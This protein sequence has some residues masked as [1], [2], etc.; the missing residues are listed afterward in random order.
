[1]HDASAFVN[2][3]PALL[4][5]TTVVLRIR[6]HVCEVD[7]TTN[8]L[9]QQAAD[10]V[11][12]DRVNLYKVY[13]C[14]LCYAGPSH[15]GLMVDIC[16]LLANKVTADPDRS[17]GVVILPNT[18]VHGSATTSMGP[19]V[20][21]RSA[22]QMFED[23]AFKLEVRDFVLLC[24][25][26]TM[27]SKIRS[28]IHPALMLFSDSKHVDK[29]NHRCHFAESELYWRKAVFSIP[30]L[31]RDDFVNPASLPTIDGKQQRLSEA[32]EGKQ[33]ITGVGLWT[34]AGRARLKRQSPAPKIKPGPHSPSSVRPQVIEALWARM[35]VTKAHHAAF[36][37][38]LPYDGTLAQAIIEMQTLDGADVPTA[39]CSSVIWAGSLEDKSAIHKYLFQEVRNIIYKLSADGTY[40]VPGLAHMP[41]VSE[42]SEM[43]PTY[44]QEDYTVTR[45][46]DDDTLP[47]LQSVRPFPFK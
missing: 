28:L 24:D 15:G 14:N 46:M 33:H 39:S 4:V 6:C 36:I 43:R 21:Q 32:A 47:V 1:M 10:T 29:P 45:P 7:C 8:S 20:A 40:N 37:D 22:T 2:A 19:T 17:V 35:P 42:T 13:V 27:Y 12:L 34:K 23:A 41:K 44:K 25:K 38:L 31:A 11:T 5:A 26:T 18:G 3:G 9:L 30:T 16:R